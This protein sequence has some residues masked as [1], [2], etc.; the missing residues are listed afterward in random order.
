[1]Y[2]LV[3]GTMDQEDI[4]QEDYAKHLKYRKN[5]RTNCGKKEVNQQL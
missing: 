1:M 2:T 5:N 3:K 4:S